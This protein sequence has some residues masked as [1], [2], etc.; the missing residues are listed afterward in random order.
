MLL[1][2]KGENND[3]PTY[4]ATISLR[5]YKTTNQDV[6][7]TVIQSNGN[8]ARLPYYHGFV[9]NTNAIPTTLGDQALLIQPESSE[10]LTA[11]YIV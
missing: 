9:T 2:I 8:T 4:S 7:M 1:S 5:T 10:K 6:S 11:Y 3:G